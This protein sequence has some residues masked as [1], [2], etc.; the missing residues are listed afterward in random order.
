M[1]LL[2]IPSGDLPSGLF[3]IGVEAECRGHCGPRMDCTQVSTDPP[4]WA[5][6]MADERCE[7]CDGTGEV[8]L[9]PYPNS[10][11]AKPMVCGHCIDGHPLRPV[12]VKCGNCAGHGEI[13][14]DRIGGGWSDECPACDGHGY[15]TVGE[16]AV[17]A[18]V[19]VFHNDVTP[20]PLHECIEFWDDGVC[21]YW[22]AQAIHDGVASPIHFPDAERFPFALI[23]RMREN[24]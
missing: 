5:V 22:N 4:S 12:R 1:T 19:E 20:A 13:S 17:L 23:A 2:T 8:T 9:T 21:F 24:Q 15:R 10:I 6:E 14:N 3:A 11:N 7:T 18:C 16:A